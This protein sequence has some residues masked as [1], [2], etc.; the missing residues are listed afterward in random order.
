MKPLRTRLA[1]V[2]AA[3]FPALSSAVTSDRV[4]IDNNAIY[5]SSDVVIAE[6]AEGAPEP[7]G[8]VGASPIFGGD[9]WGVLNIYL[10]EP[11]TNLISDHLFSVDGDAQSCNL[12]PADPDGADCLFFS[13]DASRDPTIGTECTFG[14]AFCREETG[15]LQEVT[16][17]VAAQNH[18]GIFEGGRIFI[19]SDNESVPEPAT[20]A[21]LGLGIAGLAATRRRKRN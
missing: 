1:I 16:D 20:L 21:L 14:P 17:M 15:G 8:F 12:N 7:G 2:I 10:T 3:L 11:G 6:G 13:S 5:P 9:G 19:Q 4:V 18:Q